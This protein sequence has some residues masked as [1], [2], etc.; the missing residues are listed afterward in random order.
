MNHINII[1]HKI[2]YLSN[3]WTY[4][5]CSVISLG[6]SI[7]IVRTSRTNQTCFTRSRNFFPSPLVSRL[8][9]KEVPLHPP[10]SPPSPIGL[11]VNLARSAAGFASLSLSPRS[12]PRP[13]PR[14]C[15]LILYFN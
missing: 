8:S 2:D 15:P 1:N 7:S 6:G 10:S 9:M 14:P 4:L 13:R 5:F 11:S 12:R 3:H